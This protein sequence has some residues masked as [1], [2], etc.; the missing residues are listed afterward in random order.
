M[1]HM[2]DPLPPAEELRRPRSRFPWRWLIPALCL[3]FLLG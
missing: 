3:A 2:L 1:S